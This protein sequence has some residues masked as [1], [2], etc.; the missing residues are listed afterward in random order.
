[1]AGGAENTIGIGPGKSGTPLNFEISAAKEL[2][3]GGIDVSLDYRRLESSC[4]FY[5]RGTGFNFGMKDGKVSVTYKLKTESK[6]PETITE[7]TRYEIPSD[8][9]F[10][11]FRFL[12][13]PGKGKAEIFVNNVVIWSHESAP[14]NTMFWDEEAPLI[15]GKD[16]KGNGTGIPC[17][18]N[19]TVKAT[20]QV[21]KL[22]VTLL[23]FEARAE[24]KYV[25]ITWFTADEADIDSFIVERSS[26]AISFNEV[27]RVKAA[28]NS[29][30]LLAYALLDKQPSPG[31]TYYRLVP[32]NLPLRSMT[33]SL[34]GYKYR[35]AAGD[36]KLTDIQNMESK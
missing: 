10:R 8:S 11:N 24:D 34:I 2:N 31:V 27:G 26:D 16:M 17:V 23:N 3:L 29:S 35:G 36:A 20:Q 32:S 7:S 15:L 30:S 9:E 22:P 21:N 13:N 6:K 14:G 1:M 19:A 4:S 18:D 25:M 12:Y 28:G 5:S 33:I